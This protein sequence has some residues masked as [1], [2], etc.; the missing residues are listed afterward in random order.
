MIKSL[1]SLLFL[2]VVFT[3][4]VNGQNVATQPTTTPASCDGSAYIND[5]LTYISWSW[6]DSQNNLIQQD[7]LHV[8]DLCTGNYLFN[9]VT[10]SGSGSIP[11]VI[12]Y[13]ICYNSTLAA[14]VSGVQST[15]I[16]CNGSVT[17]SVSGGVSP[18]SYQWNTSN[19]NYTNVTSLSN[20]CEGTFQFVV[21]DA[22]GCTAFAY[23]QITDVCSPFEVTLSS[24]NVTVN[25]QCDGA[26]SLSS[27]N[28]Q[29]PYT[30]LWSTN[31]TTQSI[32]NLCIGYYSLLVT[33]A[34]G[35]VD[36]VSETIL[37]PCNFMNSGASVTQNTGL[38]NCN[39]SAFISTNGGSSPFTYTWSNG[40]TGI[41]EINLCTGNYT[42]I[43][44]DASGCTNTVYFSVS[45]S[46]V[47]NCYFDLLLQPT[48]LISGDTC[49]GS[50][51]IANTSN[52]QAPFVYAW[53]NG[54]STPS[55]DNLCAGWY[56]LTILDA[57]GC[58]GVDTTFIADSS[59]TSPCIGFGANVTTTFVTDPA[60]CDGTAL[61]SV[62]G[63][64]AP[65]NV[66][67]SNAETTAQIENLCIGDYW[68]TVSDAIGCTV[69]YD[70]SISTYNQPLSAEL[71]VYD[72]TVSGACD[73]AASL[74]VSGGV[75]P[76]SYLHSNGLTTAS[77]TNLCSGIYD[78]I[79]TDSNGDTIFVSY[80]IADP[81]NVIFNLPFPDS[82]I[83]DSLYNNLAIENCDIDYNTVSAAYIYNASLAGF[84]SV[85]VTWAIYDSSGVNYITETY[86]FGGGNGVYSLELSVYCPQK[87]VEQYLKVYDQL[88][89]SDELGITESAFNHL[90]VSPNPFSESVFIQF[91]K[92]GGYSIE[93][94]DVTGRK[95]LS[96]FIS[97]QSATQLNGLN[98]LA[99]G[100]YLLYIHNG[101]ESVVRKIVK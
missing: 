94:L 99:Q 70:V 12:T 8:T 52:G 74:I 39:G 17:A 77:V 40:A 32:T 16:P 91:E 84:D 7:S 43:V 68:V 73:G 101:S 22:N 27:A 95:L 57:N 66:V 11:F 18:Y 85:T 28:G 31:A 60:T 62:Y 15:Q 24:T 98:A 44:S 9:Y 2:C 3:Q 67:W 88:Y 76:Y 14:S 89:I 64:Y 20:Q 75:A 30:Y 10:A 90:I 82:T 83:V 1:I 33:D 48:S 19:G 23:A 25:G 5:T 13:N 53:S 4:T 80:I 86:Y 59:E 46:S 65:F 37:S 55:I 81:G 79:V 61:A 72:E 92:H 38:N 41:S 35:C 34:N 58:I 63:E 100:E 96:H 87:S 42:V 21:T 26:L 36:T 29:A 56:G 50:I 93:L 71:T 54:A 97:A 69:V 47:N 51:T 49:M 45:D 6:T 78:A